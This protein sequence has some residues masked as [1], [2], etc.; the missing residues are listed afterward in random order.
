MNL[1][2]DFFRIAAADLPGRGVRRV[3]SL[4]GVLLVGA[5]QLGVADCLAGIGF[6]D[7][8]FGKFSVDLFWFVVG[9]SGLWG[10]G[11]Y[12]LC[13]RSRARRILPSEILLGSFSDTLL[14]VSILDI[15]YDCY[16]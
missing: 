12:E 6:A 7:P 15:V 5:S 8:G 9:L 2:R 11:A 10:G 14:V 4:H 16:L 13:P 3:F 1:F